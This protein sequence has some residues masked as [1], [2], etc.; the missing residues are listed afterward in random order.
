M[1]PGSLLVGEGEHGR[2]AGTLGESLGL[3]ISP[4]F[5]LSPWQSASSSVGI[6]CDSVSPLKS[7]SLSPSI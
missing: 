2:Q 3:G 7:L 1:L 4:H 6:Y 5:S